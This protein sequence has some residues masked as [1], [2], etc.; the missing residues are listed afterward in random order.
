MKEAEM[1]QIAQFMRRLVLDK[2]PPCK[3][4]QEVSE[5]KSQY[6][7]VRYSLLGGMHE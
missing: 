1:A 6:M 5:F 2:E 4:A 3:I 7:E